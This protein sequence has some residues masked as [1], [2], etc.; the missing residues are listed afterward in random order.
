MIGKAWSSINSTLHSASISCPM[1]MLI[2]ELSV[3]CS[4][5]P[6]GFLVV[7]SSDV[8]LDICQLN[9]PVVFNDNSVA[10]ITVPEEPETAKNHVI[11][12]SCVPQSHENRNS[13]HSN[14]LTN[15][16]ISFV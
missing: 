9:S 13:I 16:L 6:F 7:A 4:T 12:L 10:I 3:F 11:H 1:G 15:R 5:A 8:L 14:N 2:S